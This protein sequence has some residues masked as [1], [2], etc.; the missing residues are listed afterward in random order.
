MFY[1]RSVVKSEIRE[2]QEQWLDVAFEQVVGDVFGDHFAIGFEGVEVGIA[3][4]CGD[5]EA[6][7]EELAEVRVVAGISG[8][9]VG[10]EAG[11]KT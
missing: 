11:R 3:E 5:F 9:V 2:S 6:D 8:L 10:R 4:L 1:R 7:V